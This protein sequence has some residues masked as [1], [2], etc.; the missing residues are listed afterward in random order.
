M[1]HG[2][3]VSSLDGVGKSWQMMVGYD[4]RMSERGP[5]RGADREARNASVLIQTFN[6]VFSDFQIYEI[7]KLTEKWLTE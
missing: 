1:R 7:Q 4:A 2:L 3:G 5:A 6:Q